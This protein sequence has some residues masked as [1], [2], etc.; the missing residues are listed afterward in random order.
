MKEDELWLIWRVADPKSENRRRY[1]IGTLKW[2]EEKDLYEF[3]YDYNHDFKEALSAGFS[4]FPG[5]ENTTKGHIYT[6]EGSLFP[7]I[8]SRLPKPERDDY[9]D[10]LNRYGLDVKDS[11]FKVLST[12]KGRQITDNFEFVPAFNTEKI[13]FDIAGVSHLQKSELL[14][15]FEDGHLRNGAKLRLSLDKENEYDKFAIKILLPIKEKNIFLGYVPRYYSKDLT[16]IIEKGT[17]YSA[18]ITAINLH[19]KIRDEG[20]SARIRLIFA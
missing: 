6:S 8:S 3:E 19:S 10:L 9:L 18:I 7:T 20:I 17:E 16:E 12:T 15:H 13:E 5:F 1:R 14:K 2:I 11:P 4:Y